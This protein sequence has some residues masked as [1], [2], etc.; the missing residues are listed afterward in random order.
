MTPPPPAAPVPVSPPSELPLQEGGGTRPFWPVMI[1][2]T[3]MGMVALA[4]LLLLICAWTKP[5]HLT[6]GKVTPTSTAGVPRPPTPTATAAVRPDIL[7]GGSGE[8]RVAR[9]GTFLKGRSPKPLFARSRTVLGSGKRLPQQSCSCR[10]RSWD[11]SV[12][13]AGGLR[14]LQMQQECGG[15]SETPRGS[16][17]GSCCGSTPSCSA[18][19]AQRGHPPPPTPT[20]PT[21]LAVPE[22]GPRA[23][24]IEGALSGSGRLHTPWR[25]RSRHWA[26]S[27]TTSMWCLSE[28]PPKSSFSTALPPPYTTPYHRPIPPPT[29]A[30]G[31]KGV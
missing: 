19:A 22:L 21:T 1:G 9:P 4:A 17:T 25:G 3:C 27:H 13:T 30:L 15:S 20:P 2:L 28:P 16:S 5:K 7:P 24:S 6:V 12:G 23:S 14:A 18:K 11:G 29:T 10:S 8:Y 26:L 31:P